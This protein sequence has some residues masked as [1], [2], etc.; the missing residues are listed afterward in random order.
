MNARCRA[1]SSSTLGCIALMSAGEWGDAA[2]IS[3]GGDRYSELVE[4]DVWV[5]A[6]TTRSTRSLTRLLRLPPGY[7]VSIVAQTLSALSSATG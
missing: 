2:E 5:R 3:L 6:I 4:V 7:W 1:A